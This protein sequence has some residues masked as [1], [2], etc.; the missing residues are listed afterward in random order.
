[1]AKK[2]EEILK[3]VLSSLD[4]PEE[5]TN[6]LLSGEK[7]I[8]DFEEYKD[9]TFIAKKLAYSDKDI[10]AGIIGNI[11]TKIN[12]HFMDKFGLSKED[13]EDKKVEDLVD[14]IQENHE[15][16][17]KKIKEESG[18]EDDEKVKTLQSKVTELET[19]AK[20]WENKFMEANKEKDQM[21]QDFDGKVKEFKINDL[22]SGYRKQVETELIKEISPLEKKGFEQEISKYKF[23]LSEDGTDLIPLNEDGTKVLNNKK[24]G[25]A[26]TL[27][28]LR[29]IA[30]ENKILDMTNG[31]EGD[32][33]K[34]TPPT[35]TPTPSNHTGE[36]KRTKLAD[37]YESVIMNGQGS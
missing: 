15:S 14:M 23:D 25:H 12:K 11:T 3:E 24:T 32:Q 6:G 33:G 34:P 29:T 13:I 18:Q 36:V 8:K 22:L 30:Q 7:E 35:P 17:I 27:D 5:I 20:D 16:A 2:P 21:R 26:N 31:G 37:K 4:T 28:V 1:M 19:S 10:K 9:E